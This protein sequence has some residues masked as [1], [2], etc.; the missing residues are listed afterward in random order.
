MSNVELPLG[1][2]R[3]DAIKGLRHT[4]RL[5]EEAQRL[6]DP[7]FVRW[8]DLDTMID[9]IEAHGFP[10]PAAP[11]ADEVKPQAIG[12]HAQIIEVATKGKGARPTRYLGIGCA[13]R[14]LGV[15]RWHLLRVIQGR[16]QSKR[17]ETWLKDNLR[18]AL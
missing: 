11:V 10:P 8:P 9:H 17:I 16:N 3:E 4:V 12:K 7:D 1:V 13:A 2:S 18:R 5:A 14:E 6:V 15:T